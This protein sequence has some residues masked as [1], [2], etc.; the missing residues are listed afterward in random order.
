MLPAN[1]S[2]SSALT[3]YERFSTDF[4]SGNFH[5]LYGASAG[6]GDGTRDVQLGQLGVNSVSTHSPFR[7]EGDDLARPVHRV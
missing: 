2:V 5:S 4:L 6:D 3:M 1:W 7:F